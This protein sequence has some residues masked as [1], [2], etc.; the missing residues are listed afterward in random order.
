MT[1]QTPPSGL[2]QDLRVELTPISSL[3]EYTRNARTHSEE[4]IRK[5]AKSIRA[6]GFVNPILVGDDGTIIAGHGRIEAA[7]Q[8]G[9]E[10]VPT[11]RLSHLSESERRAYVLADNRLAELADW[12][13]EILAIEL[14]SLLDIDTE[15]DIDVIGFETAEIDMLIQ[16]VPSDVDPKD[17][18]PELDEDIPIVSQQGDRWQLGD[19]GLICGD[20]RDQDI[21][22]RLMGNERARV[23]ISDPPYN[24]PIQGHVR[25]HGKASHSEFAM[26][27]GEMSEAEFIHF[28]S[29]FLIA[30]T[31][32]LMDGALL[33]VFM[34]WRHI[35]EVLS[36]A[37]Q[38]QL[39]QIN[40]CIWNKDNG[41]MG[42]FYRSKYELV[43][44]FKLGNATHVNNV[45]LGKYGRYRTN[46]WDYPGVNSFH[47]DRDEALEIHPTVKPVALIADAILDSTHHDEIVLDPFGGSGTTL[48]SAE[49]TGR[50]ARLIEIEPRYVDVS[51]R[52]WQNA[53]GKQAIHTETGLT[54]EDLAQV[55]SVPLACL[56]STT[57][58]EVRHGE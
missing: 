9:L 1:R 12:D 13:N 50:R 56:A 31:P 35:I 5:I 28:L 8:L 34:D 36:A 55:R 26:A 2:L 46:V 10:Q 45:E 37:K 4:H 25:G 53:T 52:R 16:D 58:A 19:H 38:A 18:L 17:T 33:Y 42:S 15:F 22:S 39:S 24:V 27:S 49:R 54:F 32:Y 14:Q 51:I 21:Y 7:K 43:F 41:G 44:V 48:L 29:D 6:F 11:I 3:Q 20:A 23:L 47:K 30:G 40:L 57:S